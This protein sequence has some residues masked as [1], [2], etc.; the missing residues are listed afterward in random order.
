MSKTT[1][2]PNSQ[3][4]PFLGCI[5]NQLLI[6]GERFPLWCRP[7]QP[8]DETWRPHDADTVAVVD[9]PRSEHEHNH[10]T[11]EIHDPDLIV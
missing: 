8:D 6:T 11:E 4:F 9:Q 10:S 5:S 2:F 1:I 3:K 7:P